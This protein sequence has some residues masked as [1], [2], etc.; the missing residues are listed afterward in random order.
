MPSENK[1][2]VPKGK[3]TKV[4]ELNKLA[5]TVFELAEIYLD[6]KYVI[7]KNIV[8]DTLELK[9]KGSG[10]SF[11]ILEDESNLFIELQKS[12]INISM[13]KLKA[14]LRS[15]YVSKY[16]PI[17]NY[18][19][20][21]PKWNKKKDMIEHLAGYVKVPEDQRARFNLQFK[22]M[23]VRTIACALNEKVFNKQ[24]FVLIQQRQNT[25]KTSFLRWLCPEQLNEYYTEN[26][27]FDDKDS[28]I[29]IT[30]NFIINIDELAHLHKTEINKLKSFISK[31]DDKSRRAYA[32]RAVRRIRRASF[33][34]STDDMEFLSDTTGNVRWVCFQIEGI[35]FKYSKDIILNEIWSQSYTH[36]KE[37]FQFQ[38]TNNEVRENEIMNQNFMKVPPECEVIGRYL[39]PGDKENHS[40]FLTATEIANL[41]RSCFNL[42]KINEVSTGK[43]M[44][45]LGFEKGSQYQKNT[46]S[47]YTIKGY[48]IKLEGK[49]KIV[50]TM[51]TH[52]DSRYVINT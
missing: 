32:S 6:R 50:E 45:F 38:L 14:V 25:G 17:L 40:Y 3:N 10:D 1:K 33:V 43:A 37:G 34:G 29:S 2:T 52:L 7:R 44:S 51:K 39:A 31:Q 36:Y 26:I 35:D 8:L 49:E 30:E 47:P 16:D 42:T 15:D 41:V 5:P 28:N 13:E 27:N 12:R 48:F 46:N 24:I 23:L 18:F 9:L 22:K 4:R 11:H 20:G 19:D 21:L